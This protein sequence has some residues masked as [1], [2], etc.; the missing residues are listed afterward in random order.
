MLRQAALICAISCFSICCGGAAPGPGAVAAPAPAPVPT[1]PPP[2]AQATPA[3]AAPAAGPTTTPAP[4]PATIHASAI[5]IDTHDDI[6][7][8]L[9]IDAA[10]LGKSL[11]DAQTDIPRMQAGGLDAEFLS[12]WVAPM[13][14]PGEKA[15]AQ[16]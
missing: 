5:V 14:Y 7:Q 3:P 1:A 2:T 4:T 15:Y 10:D 16:S 8:R 13:L 11:P 6:T 9:V 12:V